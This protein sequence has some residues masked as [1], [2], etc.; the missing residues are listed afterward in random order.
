MKHV[1]H[2]SDDNPLSPQVCGFNLRHLICEIS[3]S[4]LP[5]SKTL[6]SECFHGTRSKLNCGCVAAVSGGNYWKNG[7]FPKYTEQLYT[8]AH[9]MYF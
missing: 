9:A 4:G 8:V 3:Y 6:M 2:A 5:K 7:N 1:I